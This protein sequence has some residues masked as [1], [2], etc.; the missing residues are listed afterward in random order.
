MQRLRVVDARRR[1]ARATAVLGAPLGEQS[2][3]PGERSTVLGQPIGDAHGSPRVRRG[4][5]EAL[6]L[7]VAEALG[8][9]GRRERWQCPL[10][11]AEPAG[12]VEQGSDD[13][14]GPSIADAGDRGVERGE[15]LAGHRDMFAAGHVVIPD[16][17]A[18]VTC[19]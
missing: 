3:R 2:E 10:E 1:R 18:T 15:V 12:A 19:Y 14:Q 13:E 4:D 11:L 8:Q 17:D 9:D 5:D 6:A 7:E 16:P